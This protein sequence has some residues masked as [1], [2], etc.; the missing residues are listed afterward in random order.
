MI[1]CLQSKEK[2]SERLIREWLEN[3]MSEMVLNFSMD[4]LN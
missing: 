2:N 3:L 4:P 1:I